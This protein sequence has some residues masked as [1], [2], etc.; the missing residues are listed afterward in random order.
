LWTTITAALLAHF[1]A[2]FGKLLDALG[3][4]FANVITRG[5]PLL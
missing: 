1:F 3:N 4:G 2:G 5:A